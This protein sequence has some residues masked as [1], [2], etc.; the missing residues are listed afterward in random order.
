VSR[1]R[2]ESLDLHPGLV[3]HDGRQG[4]SITAIHQTWADVEADWSPSRYT[5]TAETM[6]DFLHN[7]LSVRG[8]FGRLLLALAN[9]QAS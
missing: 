4:G 3:V 5:L 9:A 1:R 8:E 6:A 2:A 7:L